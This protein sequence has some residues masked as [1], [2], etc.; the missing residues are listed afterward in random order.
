VLLELK[1]TTTK[2]KDTLLKLHAATTGYM[3][4]LAGLAGKDAYSISADIDKVSGSI[5]AFDE[6]GISAEHVQAYS[7]IVGSV[8]DWAMAAQ[9][10]K[11]VKRMVKENGEDMDKLLEAMEFATEG[12]GRVLKQEATAS[13]ALAEDRAFVWNEKMPGD[14][15]SLTVERR[16]VLSALLRKTSAA[17]KA[18]QAKALEAQKAAA[19]GL[20]EIRVAHRKMV[21]NVD[22]L[23]AKDVQALLK[24]AA[25]DLKA[26]RNDISEL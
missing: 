23:K 20:K 7:N 4:A 3:A 13:E 24:K 17:E 2:Q 5:A 12:Y 6:L 26:I 1:D 14:T 22:R 19:A 25:S 11:D 10:A 18:E 15:N 9:Q 8:V 16:E 21:D